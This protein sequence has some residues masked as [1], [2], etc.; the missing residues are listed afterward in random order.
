MWNQLRFIVLIALLFVA[1]GPRLLSEAWS[2]DRADPVPLPRYHFDVDLNYRVHR[3]D[4]VQRVTLPNTFG[5][6]IS[7]VVFNVP[8]A[9]TRGVFDLDRVEVEAEDVAYTLDQTTLTV[10]LPRDLKPDE[11]ITL[12]L[13]YTVRVPELNEPQSFGDAN[14]A[15]TDD[16]MSIGYWYPMLAPYR[17]GAGWYATDWQS[18]GD[19]F[20]SEVADYTAVITTTPDVTVV[21]GGDLSRT[22]NVWRYDLPRAR[23]FGMIAS[24][25]YRALSVPFGGVTYT[26]YTLPRHA[27]LASIALKTTIQAALLYTSLYGPYPYQS[28]RVAEFSG[29]WSMEF[30]GFVVLGASEFDD[31]DGTLR[32]RLIRIAAHEVSHQ[33]WYGVVGNDQIREPWLDEGLARFNELRYY[34]AY[35][36]QDVDW[37]WDNAIGTNRPTAAVNSP[38]NA[39]N[40]HSAYLSSVYNQGA[41]FFDALRTRLGVDRFKAFLRDLYQ[42]G[43]FRLITTQDFLKVLQEDARID[44]RSV[45]RRFLR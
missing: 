17:S 45:V 43:S 4:T 36:P 23:T 11:V 35:A 20:V 34:E 28:L 1:P 29:P 37:W 44:V 14:L 30:S 6:P 40:T 19:P 33:W 41:R 22:G 32:N 42:R 31:Y 13:K 7:E 10:K 24:N 38:V 27:S 15:Y 12:T 2:D 3:L 18:I 5:E 16:A 39:F 25:D 21:A 26:V 9:H 8:A